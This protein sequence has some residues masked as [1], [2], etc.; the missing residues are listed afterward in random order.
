[1]LDRDGMV[2]GIATMAVKGGPRAGLSFAVAIDHADR[3][4][5]GQRVSGAAETAA[6]RPDRG[7]DW[8]SGERESGELR[9]RRATRQRAR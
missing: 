1:M 6:G 7:D 8:S 4:D 2:I 3:A 9:Q 5:A